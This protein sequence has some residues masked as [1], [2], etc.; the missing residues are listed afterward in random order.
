MNLN[1]TKW[2][3]ADLDAKRSRQKYFQGS[4]ICANGHQF[5]TRL[6]PMESEF[7]PDKCSSCG[8][9]IIVKC[10]S[11]SSRIRGNKTGN[12]YHQY[13]DA[14]SPGFCDICGVLFPWA[15]RAQRISELQNRLEDFEVD[16]DARKIINLELLKL[17]NSAITV[18]EERGIW[19][20]VAEKAG[21]AFYNPAVIEIIQ[22]IA[23]KVLLKSMGM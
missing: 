6:E 22:G 9:N 18:E 7:I 2:P 13:D 23:S 14:E 11:C 20:K 21:K 8:K 12:G 4:A 17:D 5:S 1:D 16:E 10:P 3:Q 19:D 15:T